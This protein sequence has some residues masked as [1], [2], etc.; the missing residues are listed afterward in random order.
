MT[1][2]PRLPRHVSLLVAV[3]LTVVAVLP[4]SASSA[5]PVVLNA[6]ALASLNA[7]YRLL[8]T[9]QTTDALVPDRGEVG[10]ERTSGERFAATLYRRDF[11]A[12]YGV[13]FTGIE[14]QLITT[15]LEVSGS[16]A[17]LHAD[18][19]VQMRFV[20]GWESDP[21][22]DVT[23][24]RIPHSFVFTQTGRAWRL[25]FDDAGGM[26][27]GGRAVDASPNLTPARIRPQSSLAGG[28]FAALDPERMSA[29]DIRPDV[30]TR[31]DSAYG[32]YW[33]NPAGDYAYN[34]AYSRNPAYRDYA[35][36]DCTNFVSQALRAGGWTDKLGWWRDWNNWWY[37]AQNETES[38]TYVAA[39]RQFMSTSGRGQSLAYINDLQKGDVLQVD[40]SQNGSWDHGLIVDAKYSSNLADIYVS[41]HNTDTQHRPMSDFL[42]AVQTQY[43]NSTYNAWH[44]IFTS[45]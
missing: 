41:Y 28:R 23:R 10:V 45:N 3:A 27:D 34:W 44:I 22:R 17:V 11:N 14:V 30:S 21:E 2:L 29:L 15:A 1:H 4:A 18:E 8:L 9:G 38:W 31:I 24:M 26:R 42:G 36:N 13:R 12:Q 32:T 20:S 43:G 16:T 7:G 25:D 39:M 19:H 6:Q 35:P 5:D 33:P 37:N 40:F